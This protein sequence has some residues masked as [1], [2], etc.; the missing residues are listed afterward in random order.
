MLALASWIM[1]TVG[2][3]LDCADVFRVHIIGI[4]TC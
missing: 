3:I 4:T 2:L 1:H